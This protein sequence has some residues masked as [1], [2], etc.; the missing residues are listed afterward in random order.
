MDGGIN[1]ALGVGGDTGV[2]TAIVEEDAIKVQCAVDVA[3]VLG[4]VEERLAL[5]DPAHYRT[6]P[7][8]ST[9]VHLR[10]RG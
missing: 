1:D 9:T 8:A 6:G 4:P 10:R 5:F 7:T 3:D 2:V